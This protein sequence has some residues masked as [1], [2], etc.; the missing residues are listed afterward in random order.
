MELSLDDGINNLENFKKSFEFCSKK[1]EKTA[2]LVSSKFSK[3]FKSHEKVRSAL[4]LIA[5]VPEQY[6]LRAA[7]KMKGFISIHFPKTRKSIGI[8]V[9]IF[10]F[11]MLCLLVF[12]LLL[13]LSPS[14]FWSTRSERRAAELVKENAQLKKDLKE[15][16]KQIDVLGQQVDTQKVRIDTQQNMQKTLKQNLQMLQTIQ[17]E[18]SQAISNLD[19]E[20]VNKDDKVLR[21][22]IRKIAEWQKETCQEEKREAAAYK[23]KKYCLKLGSKQTSLDLIGLNLTTLPDV[24]NDPIFEKL[25][26]LNLSDNRLEVLPETITELSSLKVLRLSRNPLRVIPETIHQF[27][28]LKKLNMKGISTLTEIPIQALTQ[29]PSTC[30]I[31]LKDTKLPENVQQSLLSETKRPNYTGPKIHFENRIFNLKKKFQRS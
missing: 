14:L 16:K 10:T 27:K 24:F 15:H 6:S 20:S 21:G 1:E 23:L 25:T 30:M 17:E 5:K 22:T 26:M 12:P 4:K 2:K 7:D 9:R 13:I 19:K 29:L 28:A 31:H 8:F 11:I 3:F 18:A